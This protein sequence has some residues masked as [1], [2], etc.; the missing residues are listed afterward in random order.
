[1]L[2]LA[3]SVDTED[4]NFFACRNFD[5]ILVI[6][7]F[8]GNRTGTYW[9][10]RFPNR[11]DHSNYRQM[12]TQCHHR[13]TTLTYESCQSFPLPG[14]LRISC[15]GLRSPPRP[16]PRSTAGVPPPCLPTGEIT[17][18]A[19]QGRRGRSVPHLVSP[20]GGALLGVQDPVGP[21]PPSWRIVTP[22]RGDRGPGLRPSRGTWSAAVFFFR[23]AAVAGDLVHSQSSPH[24]AK[25]RLSAGR[26]RDHP[27]MEIVP[28]SHHHQTRYCVDISV[29]HRYIG[30]GSVYRRSFKDK[31]VTI[32]ACPPHQKSRLHC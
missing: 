8:L 16:P 4:R 27:V 15:P 22:R 12:R 21:P 29:Y 31:F 30:D 5:D 13:D 10:L 2:D 20:P 24:R 26:A 19:P 17:T 32:R 14:N 9:S 1:M 28:N 7:K 3:P 25:Q 6:K 11:A 18:L 23:R